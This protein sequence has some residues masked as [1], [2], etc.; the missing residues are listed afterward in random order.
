MHSIQKKG[1]LPIQITPPR[2]RA[3]A[4]HLS[5]PTS[6]E[7]PGQSHTFGCTYTPIPISILEPYRRQN[8]VWD[9]YSYRQMQN[10]AND[11]SRQ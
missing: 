9:P 1:A 2:H 5:D 3:Y 4:N 6:T 7:T 10:Q 8:S 11:R